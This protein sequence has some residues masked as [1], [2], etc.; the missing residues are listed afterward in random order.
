MPARRPRLAA[1]GSRA[2]LRSLAFALVALLLAACGS[3]RS[4][5]APPTTSPP[6][7]NPPSATEEPATTPAPGSPGTDP[8]RIAVTLEPFARVTGGPLAMTAPDDGTNRLFVAVQQ[9]Q[10]WSI[11]GDG[12]VHPD[13]MVDLGPR[14]RSGGEQ[15]LLGIALHPGFPTDP[16]IFVDYTDTNGDTVVA[17][18][19]LDP[20]NPNRFDPDSHRQLLF[21]D[22]PYGNHNGGGV[23]FGPD[24]FL[25]VSLGDGGSG[26]DPHGN[27]QRLD[28][29]L[30]KILR[31]DVE[32]PGDLGYVIPEGNPFA[33]G[34]GQDEIWHYGL[35]NPWR[36][37]F[38][39]QTGDLWIG[40]VGQ[41]AFEEIDVAPA[42][43][44]GLD[45]GWNVMEGSHCYNADTC[46]TQGLTLPVSDY[47]RDLGCTV[48]GG[49]VY[50]G[51]T[52]D[53]A[54][55]IYLFADYCSGNLFA[56]NTTLAA[57]VAPSPLAPMVVGSASNGIAA[58]GE[59]AEGELYAMHLAGEISRV[60]IA[61][62]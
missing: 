4:T 5:S 62:R 41:N 27:G 28:T 50:R 19:T 14:L 22:Q 17:S 16:R 59:D 20:A 24:G 61:E 38:D 30:G 57:L 39:R 49:Y 18:L 60:V 2:A 3:D 10:I 29:L 9:G 33:G 13:P 23:L 34:D 15:G 8:G 32:A 56:I 44:G 11:E 25:Y 6:S 53:F 52:F 35:R 54:N 42:G 1:M 12:T 7:A 26:G 21:V 47:G 48:I 37:S 40:D 55:G 45:F 46:S 58:F 31:I 36:L 51:A 43:V